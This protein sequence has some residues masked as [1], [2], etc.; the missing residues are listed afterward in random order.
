[1]NRR[2]IFMCTPMGFYKRFV[3]EKTERIFKIT[4]DEKRI[5]FCLGSLSH[6]DS[7][8][9]FWPSI[10]ETINSHLETFPESTFIYFGWQV[11]EYFDKLKE[12]YPDAIY[13]G[14]YING[15]R[16]AESSIS[17]MMA[18]LYDLDRNEQRIRDRATKHFNKIESLYNAGP[19]TVNI[20]HHYAGE[21]KI[22]NCFFIN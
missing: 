15:F 18:N 6:L 16:D 2:I 22:R 9:D 17:L 1:M 4:E 12:T 14:F 21:E 10:Q 13:F 11:L 5:Y 7:K 3:T 20:L 19:P 8:E